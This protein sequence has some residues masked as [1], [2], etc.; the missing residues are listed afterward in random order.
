MYV[1]YDH[2]QPDIDRPHYHGLFAV[3]QK[4]PVVVKQYGNGNQIHA[5]V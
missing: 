3:M 2:R 4:A 1:V 5:V